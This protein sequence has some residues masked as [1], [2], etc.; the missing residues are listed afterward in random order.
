M[1]R[2]TRKMMW[3]VPLVAVFAVAGALALF[4]TQA[5]NAAQAI[6][7]PG[8]VL[9]LTAE[10]ISD[11]DGFPQEEIEL[12]WDVPT[13]GDTPRYYRID[14]SENGG[15]TW[16]S[17]KE[18]HSGTRFYHTDRPANM[19]YH[20]RVI[21]VN[22]AGAG[23]TSDIV[24]ATTA[25]SHKPEAPQGLS[26]TVGTDNTIAD[27][28]AELTIALDW[29]SSQDPPGAPVT[30]YVL[31]FSADGSAWQDARTA[32]EIEKDT[33]ITA[34]QYS[35]VGLAAGT[36]YRYQVAAVNAEER[37]GGQ[38]EWSSIDTESTN[39]GATPPEITTAT[40]RTAAAPAVPTVIL[41]WDA[42]TDPPGDPIIS[43]E[44]Q[45][46]PDSERS[47]T[48][49]VEVDATAW[50]T[51]K[52]G[53]S[54]PEG[55]DIH[56][57]EIAK[58]DVDKNTTFDADFKSDV[59]WAFRIRAKNRAKDNDN[60]GAKD[61]GD[62]PWSQTIAVNARVPAEDPVPMGSLTV[63]RHTD[64]TEGRTG[65]SLSWT[66]PK[67]SDGSD[68]TLTTPAYR[69]E[70]SDSGPSGDGYNWKAL[71]GYSG[72]DA[73]YD[74]AY[75]D[76]ATE[77][78]RLKGGQTRYYRVF[79]VHDDTDPD[80]M[81][82][83]SRPQSGTT[84]PPRQPAAPVLTATATGHTSIRLTWTVPTTDVNDD[85]TAGGSDVVIDNYVVETWNSERDRWQSLAT[86]KSTDDQHDHKNIT[87]GAT[88]SYRIAAT[89]SAGRRSQYQWD[90]VERSTVTLPEPNEPGGL[91]AEANGYDSIKL[92]WNAQAEGPEDAFV[93]S[94]RIQYSADGKT[95][96]KDLATVDAM[97][98][99]QVH[100]IYTD[101]HELEPNETRHYRLYATNA[102]GDSDQSDVA[103]ATTMSAMVPDAPT[104]VTATATSDTAITV[105]WT[106]PAANGADITGYVLQSKSGGD[107]FMTIAA[108]DASTWWETL[109]C[110]EMIAAV[111]DT[112]TDE[113][114]A[115]AMDDPFCRHYPGSAKATT[116]MNTLSDASKMVVDDTFAA[117]YGTI[118]DT[119][120]M[121]MGL[122]PETMYY[123]RV[124][125][126]N[127]VGLGEYSDGMASETTNA[128]NAAPMAGAAIVEQTVTVDS[129]V[130]VKS[131]ITDADTGD[132][133]TWSVESDI[134]TYATAE[135][136]DMGMVTITGVA[137]GMATITVTATD[138]A[139]ETATQDIMVT[140]EAADTALTAPSGVVVSTS[141]FG[142]TKSISVTWDTTS[143]QN[144]E[145]IKVALFNSDVTALAQPLITINPANDRGADTFNDVPP[146]TYYVT[147]A[148]FRTGERHKLSL[149]LKEVTVE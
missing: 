42:P 77:E 60:D 134:P 35:H 139:D 108:T 136:D 102:R 29:D 21:A 34:T 64:S 86:K 15:Y 120:Y 32:A 58:N 20:Y 13:D 132:T 69:I 73:S 74:D 90:E 106:K 149:P 63:I 2:K 91:V 61:D 48:T 37:G 40:I 144:A 43:Y 8:K 82:W 65:L 81:S 101:D 146:G 93:T 88:V 115:D 22:D 124:A 45:G 11:A 123:Y 76:T 36:E 118:A 47:S 46:Q 133:L 23:P 114:A 87:P 92:C 39:P 53:I 70:Y 56:S 104:D 105:A 107:D 66:A 140:V 95:G 12:T 142:N 54:K 6:D 38:S 18:R 55:D 137:K 25:E 68:S 100:T 7:M 126:M 125:A 52:S 138:I 79:A 135:V 83:A 30:H 97:T 51:V 9:N 31:E 98:D 14:V 10:R 127:S 103:I 145:Q 3:A 111:A 49:T 57:F 67:A 62:G 129:M 110:A 72:T 131:T 143:I 44:V 141:T 96:W 33:K 94:Y 1:S 50:Q 4:M 112:R 109:D 121:D 113:P 27:T 80:Q 122:M 5:P 17:A 89:N 130:M 26:A 78:H 19:E 28:E 117:N 41:Y 85:G 84:A 24:D 71:D 119:S 116:D 75:A 59:G 147:V 16:V 148:S 99:D 128:T